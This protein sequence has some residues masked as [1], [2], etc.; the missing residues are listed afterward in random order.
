VSPSFFNHF[1]GLSSPNFHLFPIFFRTTEVYEKGIFRNTKN[2]IMLVA[3]TVILLGVGG[4]G[5]FGSGEYHS[6]VGLYEPSAEKKLKTLLRII[7][8][9]T[10]FPPGFF[11]KCPIKTTA[12]LCYIVIITV[13]VKCS[14]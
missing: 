12:L 1:F 9:F 7:L 4:G 6:I 14:R 13:I 8:R 3:T 11:V 2:E 5:E 10:Y